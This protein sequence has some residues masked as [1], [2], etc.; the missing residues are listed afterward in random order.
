MGNK[1]YEKR[2][3]KIIAIIT[4]LARIFDHHGFDLYEVGGSVRDKILGIPNDDFDFTT[5]AIP[6]QIKTMLSHANVGSVYTVGEK[7]GTIGLLLDDGSKIEITTYRSEKYDRD[8]RKPRVAYHASLL[9]DLSRRDFTMNAIA[10]NVLTGKVI[11][12]FQGTVD[13]QN[14]VIRPIGSATERFNDD[15]LRMMRAVRFASKLGFRL[16]LEITDPERLDAVSAERKSEELIKILMTRRPE[17]GIHHLVEYGLMAYLVPDF[18][19]LRNVAQ[20]HYH[21][22]DAYYHTLEV[23]S[24]CMAYADI[25]DYSVSDK[26]VLMLAGL[27]HDIGK[28]STKTIENDEVHFYGHNNVG[29]DMSRSILHNLRFERDTINRVCNLVAFH[30]TPINYR[31]V[32]D[33]K[34]RSIVRFIR[35]VGEN[36][37]HLLLDLVRADVRSSRM[38]RIDFI[39]RLGERIDEALKEKPASIT[40]PIDGREIMEYFNL[41]SGRLIGTIKEFL[42][43]KV[44]DGDL[45]KD[46]KEGAFNMVKSYLGEN[47]S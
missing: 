40:S 29:A 5:N 47:L 7:F 46:D 13:I 41:K 24:R 17:M 19:Y 34:D 23:V 43:N 6:D 9:D 28:P 31:F 16:D 42:A 15:P 3:D 32:V 20:G 22:K 27:L 36:D 10:V 21:V 8:S 37:I 25:N 44:I 12:P 11:D 26:K 14:R 2:E 45:D 38:D 39:N 35:N 33:V 18:L 30:M 4:D 1:L